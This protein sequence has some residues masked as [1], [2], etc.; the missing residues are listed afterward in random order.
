MTSRLVVGP[1]NRVEGDLEV[2]LDV[3]DGRVASARVNAPMYRGFEQILPGRD[4]SD[5]LV[6]VPRICGICSV[7]QS[8]AA[9][10]ALA[11]L[12]HAEP[13]P[14]GLIVTNLMSACE[15]LADHLTHFYV[16]FMPDFARE[17]YARRPWHAEALQRFAAAG[18]ERRRIA[19]AARQRWM[20]VMGTLGGKWPH[21]LAIRPGGST[22]ALDAAERL[23]LLAKVRELRVFVERNL[24]AAP[25]E[26]FDALDSLA[27][28]QAWHAAAPTAG[29]VRCFLTIAADIGLEALGPGPGRYLSYGAYPQ[30]DGAFLFAP[31]VWDDATR[32]LQPLDT[33]AIAEDTTHA[34]LMH[35]AAPR[36]PREGLTIPVADKPAAYTWNKAPRLAGHVV[37]TGAIA[38]QLADG[39][40]LV[41]DAVAHHGGCVLTRVLARVLEFARVLPAMEAW[42]QALRPG[43]PVHAPATP[44]AEGQGVGLVEAARGALGHWISVHDG[45]IERYQIVAPTSWNFSPRDAAGTPGA[46][47]AALVGAPVAAGEATPVAVQHVVRSFDPCMVCTVH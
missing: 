3:Q 41:R 30:P 31:G 44:P 43:Q 26:A 20:T 11:D 23:R 28:L 25:L 12:A 35:E 13:P 40:P 36:H 29:D 1:F 16:F 17:S 47:E 34:W 8:I 32:T 27:A 10:R 4:P 19:I 37:E 7:S 2:T 24:L 38:R 46:L 21:S 6:I 33:G 22:R 39:H 14:D 15:N 18:G 5:A 45:R 42:L 9:A